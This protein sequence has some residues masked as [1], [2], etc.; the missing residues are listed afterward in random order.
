MPE[1]ALAVVRSPSWDLL[2]TIHTPNGDV[3]LRSRGD[4]ERTRVSTDYCENVVFGA[5]HECVTELPCA[6]TLAWIEDMVS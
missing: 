5:L 1:I 3:D 6:I 4:A 2:A